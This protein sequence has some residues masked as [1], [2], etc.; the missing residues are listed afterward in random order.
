L[1]PSKENS[2]LDFALLI[3]TIAPQTID[4]N[5]SPKVTKMRAWDGI[6]VH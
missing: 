3:I 4:A 5:A 6:A 1:T 2:V